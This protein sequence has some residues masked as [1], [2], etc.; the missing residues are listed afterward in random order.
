MH[1][2]YLFFFKRTTHKNCI[3]LNSHLGN[4]AAVFKSRA[5]S[6]LGRSTP[7][8]HRPGD[9]RQD[10]RANGAGPHPALAAWSVTRS[11]PSEHSL[12]PHP[13]EPQGAGHDTLALAHG[14]CFLHD[15]ECEEP[16]PKSAPFST[17]C[18]KCYLFPFH[19]EKTPITVL[20]KHATLIP[21]WVNLLCSP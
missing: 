17:P 8:G 10:V 9:G 16:P 11:G 18:W 19:S 14:F 5:A 1:V 7:S 3:P 15:K 12:F 4:C 2:L 6:R 21:F 20:S 13:S